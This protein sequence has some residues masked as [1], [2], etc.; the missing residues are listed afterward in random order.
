MEYFIPLFDSINVEAE[1]EKLQ[2]ELNY[3]KGFL[4]SVEVKLS[5]EKFVQN[6][7]QPLVD[8]E[9]KKQADAKAKIDILVDKIAALSDA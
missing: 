9:R 8:K 3:T 1:I 7:P 6:A 2:K 5:N 4:K